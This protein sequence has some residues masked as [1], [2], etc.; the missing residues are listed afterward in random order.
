MLQTQ[1]IESYF[2]T[3]MNISIYNMTADETNKS[4]GVIELSGKDKESH[5]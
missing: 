2:N 1:L 5:K 3:F 4:M